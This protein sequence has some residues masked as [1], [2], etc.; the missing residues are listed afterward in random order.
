[1]KANRRRDTAPERWLRSLLHH[2]RRRFRI[3][4][5]IELQAG[6]RTRPDIVFGPQRLAVYI[7]GCFWHSCPIHAT[8][9]MANQEF[10][11]A[12]LDANVARDRRTT[13]AL[14][15][16]GWRVLRIW[17]HTPLDEAAEL[18]ERALDASPRLL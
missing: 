9:P 16:E 5:P 13:E 10:W 1:M 7:D 14:Q 8:K 3:D 12:K 4:R 11:R 2:R 6:G 17:E 18:V 15:Q